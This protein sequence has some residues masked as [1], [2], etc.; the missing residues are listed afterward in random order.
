MLIVVGKR[1]KENGETEKA[2]S[3][4][5]IA[6]KVMDAFA[7]D[8]VEEKWFRATVYEYTAEQRKEVEAL[9]AE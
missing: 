5:R 3:Q 1:L 2:N 6:Q 8:F 9:L 7:E 4:F